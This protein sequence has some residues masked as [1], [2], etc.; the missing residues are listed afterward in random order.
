MASLAMPSEVHVVFDFETTGLDVA[1]GEEIIEIGA[2]PIIDGIVRE[3]CAF[4]SLI[5]PGKPIPRDSTAIHGIG[6][7]MVR[8]KPQ[9]D[10]VLPEFLRYL[11][12]QDLVAQ[13][14][15]FDMGF[16]LAGCRR[17]ELKP[18]PGK[19]SCTM[20]MSRQVFPGERRHSLD[21]ICRRLS[22][23]VGGRHRSIDDVL[24]TAKAF[25][26]LRERLAT[27]KAK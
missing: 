27:R 26:L 21:E 10:V 24:L 25:L 16:L 4:H 23:E 8:G 19:V 3:D 9:I 11:G 6:D 7:E 15:D 12:P 20:L 18:P 2:V 1:K 17:F 14:A 22:I 5:D 13:N